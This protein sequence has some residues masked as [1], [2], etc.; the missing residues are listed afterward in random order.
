MSDP[1]ASILTIDVGTSSLKAVLYGRDGRVLDSS[2]QHYSYRSERPSWA[3]G[4]PEGWWNALQVSLADL[5]SSGFAL[6]SVEA[7]SFSGQMHTAVLLDGDGQV[8]EPTILWLDRRAGRE[9]EELQR[10]LGLPPYQLNSTYTLPKLVWLSRH[11]PNVIA[12]V[13]RI[14]WPKDYLRFRLTGVICTDL[15]EAGGTGLLDWDKRCWAMERLALANLS[16]EVL[17]PICPADGDGG[18]ISPDVAPSLGLNPCLKVVIGMGDVAALFGGAPPK[19][20]RAVCSLGSSSMI[21]APLR[22]GQRVADPANR[23][24]VYPF[25]PYPLLGG[26]SSTTGAC[27]VWAYEKLWGGREEGK[28]FAECVSAALQVEPGAGGVCF[29]PYLAGERSPYWSDA[30]RGGFYGVQLA[31]DW[32][33]LVRAVMEGV[34]HSL[35]HLLD[36]Y[37]EIGAPVDELAL[38]AGGTATPGWAQ[39]IADVCQ[40]EVLVYAGRET[41]TRVLYALCQVHLGRASFQESLLSTF[42]APEVVRCRRELAEV[43]DRAYLRYRAFSAFAWK[44][45]RVE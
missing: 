15:T 20:G 40:R 22:E 43:Y 11:S 4:D 1:L 21:F 38:A 2:T 5:R 35:R 44:Q 31:H 10:Q 32:R 26:V 45:A 42:E 37:E 14:L 16:A 19:P 9:A 39:I 41:V 36:I 8:I 6:E 30:L 3:E 25:G 23:L 24:Y 17:P 27:L 12:K 34:A 29:I 7:V 28:S 13:R 18:S 33:H